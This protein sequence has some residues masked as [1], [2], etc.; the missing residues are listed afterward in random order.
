VWS[1]SDRGLSGCAWLAAAG[2]GRVV[3]DVVWSWSDP[4][5]LSCSVSVC[6]GVVGTT[7][8]ARLLPRLPVYMVVT[9][10]SGCDGGMAA[11]RDLV[12]MSAR[13]LEPLGDLGQGGRQ[14]VGKRWTSAG[15]A[16]ATSVSTVKI[17]SRWPRSA[18]ADCIRATSRTVR[19]AEAIRCSA[20]CRSRSPTRP[21]W[22][23]VPRVWSVPASGV[24]S[25]PASAEDSAREG[26]VWMEVPHRGASRRPHS[27]EDSDDTRPGSRLVT[28]VL[29]CSVPP[30][31]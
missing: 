22:G 21:L 8:A 10:V 12:A 26:S 5:S 29:V 16:K 14:L 31:K 11:D 1:R 28:C 3:D 23:E 9:G 19:A 2:S 15:R 18:A 17:S 6:R 4:I 13:C 20:A 27:G 7:W 25:D 24:R 30:V